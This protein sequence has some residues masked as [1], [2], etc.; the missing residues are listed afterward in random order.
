[1]IGWF[2]APYKRDPKVPVARYCSIRDFQTLI[3]AD[4]GTFKET[5]VLGDRAIV[6]VRANLATLQAIA[7][8]DVGGGKRIRRLPK[9][10][11]NAPLSDLSNAQKNALRNELTDAGYTVAEINARLPGN[12]GD[13]T[14]RDVLRFLA[15]RRIEMRYDR[16][17]DAI[18]FDGPTKTCRPVED[19]DAEVT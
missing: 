12:L 4:G 17:N 11:L 9:D 7:G 13:Y 1:M 10:A 16:A 3:E 15:S 18:V 5:E 14:L 8:A 2:I 6:K 19:V